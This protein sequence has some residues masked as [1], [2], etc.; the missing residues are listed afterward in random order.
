[1]PITILIV[2][3]K[4]IGFNPKYVDIPNIERKTSHT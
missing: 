1:M 3:G 4:G 2:S